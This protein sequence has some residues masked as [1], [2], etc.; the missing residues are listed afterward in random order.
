MRMVRDFWRRRLPPFVPYF[1][2]GA[3]GC[4]GAGRLQPVWVDDVAAC[5]VAALTTPAAA[6]KTYELGGPEVFTWPEF[7][8]ACQRHIPA[9]GNK[10]ILAIPAWL[11]MLLARLPGAPFNR[12]Q[13]I[14]SQEDS[15]CPGATET[16]RRDFGIQLTGF[17]TALARYAGALVELG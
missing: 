14:M 2:A 9:A 13:V 16:I 12:D 17:E 10:P 11:A 8:R 7:Y 5:M 15:I 1:G 6:G 4:G 3:C